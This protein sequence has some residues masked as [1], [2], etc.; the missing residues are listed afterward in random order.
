LSKQCT[1]NFLITLEVTSGYLQMQHNSLTDHSKESNLCFK[2]ARN[3][4]FVYNNTLFQSWKL[5][6]ISKRNTKICRSNLTV[7]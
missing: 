4:I 2:R 1:Y 6:Y 3:W 5:I 7:T